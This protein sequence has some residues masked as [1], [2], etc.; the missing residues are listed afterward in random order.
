MQVLV[1]EQIRE[2]VTPR[3]RAIHPA[4]ETIPLASE[5]PPL[6]NEAS[7]LLRFFPNSAYPGRAF[8]AAALHRAV[9]VSPRLEWI[10]NGM[11]GMD[12]VLYPQ[13]VKSSIIVTNGSGAHR[14]TIAESALSMMLAWAKRHSEHL[15]NQRQRRWQHVAHETLRGKQAL[16]IGL[17]SI[18]QTI[19]S[20]CVSFGMQ[21]I[22]VKKH[23]AGPPQTGVSRVASP[24]DL[25][26]LL[27]RADYVI[28]A[29]V[30]TAETQYLIG[31]EA[32]R[33]MKPTAYLV[34]IAR[35][36]IVDEQALCKA[37]QEGWIA[38][39]G[40]DVFSQEP[41]PLSS[42]LWDLPNV[43]ITPHNAAWSDRVE[44]EALSIFYENFNRY[45]H[46]QPLLNVVD[47]E[48]GY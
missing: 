12:G 14:H 2:R 4:T 18:G 28:I 1:P 48:G 22:G 37:L 38:G 30:L 43:T 13:L 7:V 15:D 31:E 16:I 29:A 8:D 41:L 32:F 11:T 6:P 42:P 23:P 35:G 39:A 33:I 46:N 3:L 5:E 10:H 17:G 34:N 44:E 40:L 20:L 24:H 25:H 19:A 47:K 26:E 45:I 27:P 21:V 36:A 9:A